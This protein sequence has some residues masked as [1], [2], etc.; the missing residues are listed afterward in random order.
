LGFYN[1]SGNQQP[2][3]GSVDGDYHI[4][5]QKRCIHWRLPIIDNSNKSGMLEFSV[6]GEDISA[7][8][9]IHVSFTSR[10]LFC[11]ISLT[12]IQNAQ[13]QNLDYMTEAILSTEEY[14]VA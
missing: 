10:D 14:V 2:T 11:D 9:P 3:I 1:F 6:E 12:G 4:D 13:G 8:Y 5:R 7:F